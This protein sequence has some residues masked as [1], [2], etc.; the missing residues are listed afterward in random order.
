M[1]KFQKI[2]TA[3][4]AIILSVL[5]AVGISV[6]KKISYDNKK[7][8]L[9]DSDDNK[10]SVVT[11]V[12]DGYEN[13]K[14]GYIKEK[15]KKIEFKDVLDNK[16]YDLRGKEVYY[17]DFIGIVNGEDYNEISSNGY[18]TRGKIKYYDDFIE[19]IKNNEDYGT[20]PTFENNLMHRL[21][22]LNTSDKNK[23]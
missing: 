11:I 3:F 20:Y 14:Y 12:E 17:S 5:S 7:I 21:V 15:G 9:V 13:E 16:K 10:L 19:V 8:K 2:K 18:T 4:L 1:S 23:K 22:K 6:V